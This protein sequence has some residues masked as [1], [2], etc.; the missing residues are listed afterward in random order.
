[1]QTFYH[2]FG[3]GHPLSHKVQPIVASDC[4][5]A[6]KVMFSKHGSRWAFQYNEKQWEE[7]KSTDTLLPSIEVPSK[8]YKGAAVK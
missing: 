7:M 6:L 1:M 2:T 8:K 4:T 3:I 5:E